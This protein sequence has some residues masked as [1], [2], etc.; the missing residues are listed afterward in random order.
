[1]NGLQTSIKV[2]GLGVITPIGIGLNQFT[3]ALKNGTTNFSTIE[4]EQNGAL[5]NFPIAPVNNFNLSQLVS[6][7]NI[8]E[9]VMEK[10]KRLRN[11]STSASFGVY[12]ALEAWADAGLNHANV[13]LTRVAIVSSGTNT[14]QATLKIIQDKYREKLQFMN[15]NYGLNFFDTD[16]IGVISELLGIRG[17]GHSI[18]AASASGNMA[19]IQGARLIG[20]KEYDLVL[21]V[22]PLMDLSIYE[23]QGF[24]SMG[25][26]ARAGEGV[27]P[28]QICRPFDKAHNGFVS[29]QSAGCLILESQEHAA[30][31]DKKAY[32]SIAG[33]GLSMDAN[34]NP[35]PALEGE[36]RAMRGAMVSAGVGPDEINYVNT[37][38]TAS[39]I[40]DITE[41]EA[42][43]SIG[44]KGV[45]AN[46]TKS[47]IGHGLSAAGVVEGIASLVQM[48]D[49]FIHQSHNLIN[50][51][52]DKIDWI[53]EESQSMSIE[54]AMSNNF[55]FG[56]INTSI[57]IKKN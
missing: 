13:D 30:R 53:K 51:I 18:G 33:Y 42:L 57:I 28:S 29:G 11:I 41:V 35:N 48:R 7:I 32:G 6:Q 36:Q 16:L 31:R 44:L 12:C 55:G 37:H 10:T 14:Q 3:T 8:N 38:G 19:I 25:A 56:G 46:S 24:T 9:I 40:G 5:F 23:F 49:N 45:K 26:M 27:D 43:L 39:S 2:T 4:F 20:S 54:Y 34:R 47:L 50:P 1:M 22:A 17:E 21:V 15:P 52:S